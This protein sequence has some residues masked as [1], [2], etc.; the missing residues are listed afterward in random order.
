MST[1]DQLNAVMELNRRGIDT[2]MSEQ[3]LAALNELKKR[4][5]NK[6]D[7]FIEPALTAG[8]GMAAMIP[9]GFIGAT[10][11][12][13]GAD[14]ASSVVQRVQD[15][16]TYKPGTQ[17]GSQGLQAMGQGVQTVGDYINQKLGKAATSPMGVVASTALGKSTLGADIEREGVGGALGQRTLEAT[18]SP[19]LATLAHIAPEAAVDLVG[20]K[21]VGKAIGGKQFEM[22]DIYTQAH[23]QK[24]LFAGIRAKGADLDAQK[25]A[26]QMLAEG[27]DRDE[28]WAATGWFKDVDDSWKFEIDDSQAVSVTQNAKARIAEIDDRFAEMEAKRE[29]PLIELEK[30]KEEKAQLEKTAKSLGGKTMGEV[31]QHPELYDQYTAPKYGSVYKLTSGKNKRGEYKEG[32]GIGI[33]PDA[34]VRSTALHEIQHEIQSNE[35]FALGGSPGQFKSEGM[36]LASELD[37][38]NKRLADLTDQAKKTQEYQVIENNLIDA[39]ESGD[40]ALIDK[41]ITEQIDYVESFPH[42]KRHKD[43]ARELSEKLSGVRDPYKAYQRLAGEAEARNVQ[44]RLDLTPEERR[45]TPPW[46]TLDVPENELIVRR[47]SGAAM[48]EGDTVSKNKWG[49]DV[50]TRDIKTSEGK[51][52][53][54]DYIQEDGSITILR[55]DVDKEHQNKGIG[56][57]AYKE[58]IDEQLAK[59]IEIKSD[60]NVSP[61][62]QRLYEKLKNEGYEV[63]ENESTRLVYPGSKSTLS[64][65]E[66]KKQYEARPLVNIDGV[67]TAESGWRLKGDPVYTI[68]PKGSAAK[69]Q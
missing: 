66:S 60:N 53:G 15:A 59:G 10:A 54:I 67:R 56:L 13:Y 25:K 30:L 4:K 49:E 5:G 8:T 61:Q 22:G 26:E 46:K 44:T 7:A 23:G 40:E 18:G 6:L 35:D 32:V 51:V 58:F 2:G 50:Y 19:L 34:D 29:Y 69:K 47:D 36:A 1:L 17:A 37:W 64:R 16:L 11:L 45:A 9:A 52:G 33:A 65:E 24:G 39:L 31:L 38:N 55:S 41:L 42:L 3:Q 28:I 43:K 14:T 68:K 21:G 62:A 57:N 27:A 48:S 20:G 63:V 12:P